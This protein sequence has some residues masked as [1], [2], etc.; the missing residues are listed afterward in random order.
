MRGGKG[1][2]GTDVFD[3]KKGSEKD[4]YFIVGLRGNAVS[5]VPVLSVHFFGNGDDDPLYLSGIGFVWK[6]CAVSGKIY[7]GKSRLRRSLRGGN[8]MLLYAGR[9][10][11]TDG[12]DSGL[13]LRDHL[14][15]LCPLLYEK[16][17]DGAGS[18]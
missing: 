2:K 3:H 18:L 13:Q 10:G 14:C 9:E 1:R 11:G 7:E 17:F 5:A 6:R 8:P 15:V 4:F 16:R 12:N